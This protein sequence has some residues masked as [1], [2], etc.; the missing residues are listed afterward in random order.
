MMTMRPL[1]GGLLIEPGKMV[2]L[3]PG[4]YHLMLADL[5][6]PLKQGGKFSATLEFEKAGKASVTFDVLSVG[7]K[8]PPSSGRKAPSGQKMP[9]GHKM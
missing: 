3:A 5:K 7:A 6:T 9:P 8:G 2:T 1:S 4:G